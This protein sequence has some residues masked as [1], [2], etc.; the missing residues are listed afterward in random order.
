VKNLEDYN[1]IHLDISEKDDKVH[2]TIEVPAICSYFPHRVTVDSKMVEGILLRK[3][4]HFDSLLKGGTIINK[5][6]T[7]NLKETWTFSKKSAAVEP[8]IIT[9]KKPRSTRTSKKQTKKE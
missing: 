4:I 1:E 6:E 9:T 7:F 2:V 8:P 3:K 5:S